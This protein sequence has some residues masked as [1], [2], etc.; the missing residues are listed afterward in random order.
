MR[1]KLLLIAALLAG[2]AGCGAQNQNLPL[3]AAA[4]INTAQDTIAVASVTY[5]DEDITDA[6]LSVND[7]PL[8]YGLPIQF[9]TDSGLAVDLTVPIYFA[10]LTGMAAGDIVHFVARDRVGYIL[11][12]HSGLVIPGF[13][14]ITAPTEGQSI[15]L[16]DNVEMRWSSATNAKAYV[17]SYTNVDALNNEAVE[18]L[19]EGEDDANEEGLYTEYLDAAATTA[20]VPSEFTVA[21][22]AFFSIDAINGGIFTDESFFTAVASESVEVSIADQAAQV[23]KQVSATQDL[24]FVKEYEKQFEGYTFKVRET[25]PGQI[26][27]P[28]NVDISLKLRRFKISVAFIKAYD[29]NGNE[30]FSWEKKKIMS[31]HENKYHVPF[32][33]SPGTTI[34]LGTHDAHYRGGTYS[35]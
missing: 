34:V 2:L 16:G 19:I 1:I 18:D 15:N 35:Y 20:M 30:Y 8:V 32:S 13:A 9:Q 14:Q 17:A 29:M 7:T 27:N 10:Q 3:V 25:D 6:K 12:Q 23:N 33:V 4:V 21:G 26:Q 31:S 28:G 5:G 22:E 24:A 11:Y